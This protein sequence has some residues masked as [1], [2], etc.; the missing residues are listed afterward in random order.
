M[1]VSIDVRDLLGQPGAS[2]TVHVQEPI[3]GLATEV[4]QVPE[5]RPVGAD[6]LFESVVEG[7]LVSGPL[8]GTM[9]LTC[10]RCLKPIEAPF[11][12]D[13]QELFA[14]GAGPGDDEYPLAEGVV[15]LEPMI[16]D[17][18][19]LA[20]PLAPLCRPDCL[21]LCDRCGGDRNAGECHCPP[22]TDSR[23]SALIELDLPDDRGDLIGDRRT[24]E[25]GFGPAG[26]EF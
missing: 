20:M 2:R 23:W 17:A 11:R 14:P 9:V 16:R 5:D 22:R 12:I 19:L 21:G 6:L 25:R 8:E 10:A 1:T 3:G 13:V 15:D 18:V 24:E 26:Q 4:A 7:V